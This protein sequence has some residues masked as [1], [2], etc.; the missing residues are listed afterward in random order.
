MF[1][2]KYFRQRPKVAS[3]NKQFLKRTIFSAALSTIKTSNRTQNG[4]SRLEKKSSK[5]YKRSSSVE[6]DQK[7]LKRSSESSNGLS[8][9]NSTLKKSR[10][11][12]E[13]QTKEV[14]HKK[15]KI[16]SVKS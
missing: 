8:S 16:E 13:D 2:L 9:S 14:G 10:H 4:R 11:K 12:R 6:N 5:D 3:V 15:A 1:V 7:H